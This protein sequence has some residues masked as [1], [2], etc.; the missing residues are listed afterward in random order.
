MSKARPKR[1]LA[2]VYSDDGTAG[3]WLVAD[4]PSE[5]AAKAT[6][7]PPSQFVPF[8]CANPEVGWNGRTIYLKSDVITAI[9]PPL[10]FIDVDED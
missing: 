3:A 10:E 9:A 5:A 1:A 8:V 2:T 7:T 6:D 4:T